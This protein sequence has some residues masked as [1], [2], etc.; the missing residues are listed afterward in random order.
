MIYRPL[1]DTEGTAKATGEP[2]PA[3]VLHCSLGYV[4]TTDIST[5]MLGNEYLQAA[6][7]EMIEPGARDNECCWPYTKSR[8]FYITDRNSG[9]K[10]HIDTGAEVSVVPHLHTHRKTQCKGSNPPAINTTLQ[11]LHTALARYH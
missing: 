6:S 11:F 7:R 5:I 10:L 9:L 8:L 4:G 1:D 3:H 2:D